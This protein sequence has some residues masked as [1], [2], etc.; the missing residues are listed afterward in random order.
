MFQC[1]V[2]VTLFAGTSTGPSRWVKTSLKI[3]T[4]GVP[5]VWVRT[6]WDD[7]NK[8]D[9]IKLTPRGTA[10]FLTFAPG[11]GWPSVQVFSA[12]DMRPQSQMCSS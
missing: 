5:L 6:T 10:S 8:D 3:S 12:G 4:P 1:R 9:A 7:A 11:T 2:E